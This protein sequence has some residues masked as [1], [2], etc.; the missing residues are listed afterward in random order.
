MRRSLLWGSMAL[1]PLVALAYMIPASQVTEGAPFPFPQTPFF[2]VWWYMLLGLPIAIQTCFF[3]VH[4]WQ[5]RRVGHTWRLL[6]V[7]AIFFCGVVV[8]PLYW[9]FLSDQAS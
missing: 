2:V 5:N 3:A 1:Y 9:W 4:A 6:W 8:T 7:L